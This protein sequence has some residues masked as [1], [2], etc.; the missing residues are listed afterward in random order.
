MQCDYFDAD[1]CRS[2]ALMGVPYSVQLADKDER[3]RRVLAAVAP[4]VAWL[5]PFPSAESAFRNKAKLV[6]GGV[7]GAVTVGILWS[8]AK[9][10]DL[11]AC[12]LH[13]PP[14]QRLIPRL[15]DVVDEIGLD[16]MTSP[17][18]EAS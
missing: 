17:P 14:L 4:D 1:R 2:C 7:A 11:R 9:G 18:G 16:P 15:A 13:E 12:G 5:E 8:D 6:V 3:C 10:I